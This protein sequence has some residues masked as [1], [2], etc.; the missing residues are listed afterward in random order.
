[1]GRPKTL[2]ICLNCQILKVCDRKF[3]SLK[4]YWEDKK[5]QIPY[6]KKY[7][8]GIPYVVLQEW[9]KVARGNYVS[10]EEN[11]LKIQARY[12]LNKALQAGEIQCQPCE[13]CGIEK[14]EAHHHK[15]YIKKYWLEVQWLCK[16]DHVKVHLNN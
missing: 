6:N 15:G 16:K 12:A 13:V 8:N 2:K 3:C 5:K 14:V 4:C 10:K 11:R 7:S 1:M 9:R